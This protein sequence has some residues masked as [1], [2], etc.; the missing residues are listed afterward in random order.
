MLLRA[1]WLKMAPKK[2]YTRERLDG[3]AADSAVKM[4]DSVTNGKLTCEY[5][6]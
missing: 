5:L 1:I 4:K 2:S 6:H 3:M